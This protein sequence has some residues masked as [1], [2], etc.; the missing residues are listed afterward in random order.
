MA[1]PCKTCSF[2]ALCYDAGNVAA[3]AMKLSL[4]I[5]RNKRNLVPL[6]RLGIKVNKPAADFINRKPKDCPG[7]PR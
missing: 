1:S 6:E 3:L 4:G 7:E 5:L 2:S